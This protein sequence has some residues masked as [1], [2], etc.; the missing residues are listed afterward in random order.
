M[1]V[2][3]SNANVHSQNFT[4]AVP[5][6]EDVNGMFGAGPMYTFSSSWFDAH[7]VWLG[8]QNAGPRY[9]QLLINGF[10]LDDTSQTSVLKYEQYFYQEPCPSLTNCQLMYVEFDQGAFQNLTALQVVATVFGD[11]AD[12]PLAWYM[13]DLTLSWSDNSCAAA[14]HR[15]G[16]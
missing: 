15:S 2:V 7:S 11:E 4:G 1:F 10:G 8:C 13:D 3:D 9:C 12:T 14:V 5:S 6:G 16:G